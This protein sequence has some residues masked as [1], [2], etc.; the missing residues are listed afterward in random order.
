MAYRALE[1][2]INLHD[3][4]RG[5]FRTSLGELLLIQDGEEP[6]LL[7]RRCPHQGALLDEGR[8]SDGVITCPWHQLRFSLRDGRCVNGG[9][10][11]LAI[12]SLAYEGNTIGVVE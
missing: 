8:V 7:A 6:Y 11:A 2:L 12:H 5:V 10:K 9:C 1:K 4:Y 3:G